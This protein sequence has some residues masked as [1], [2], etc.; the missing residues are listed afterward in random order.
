METFY[1]AN[2]RIRDVKEY[3]WWISELPRVQYSTNAAFQGGINSEPISVYFG[4]KPAFL[5]ADLILLSNVV[6]IQR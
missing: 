1:H 6:S 3:S 2:A 4:R 5:V